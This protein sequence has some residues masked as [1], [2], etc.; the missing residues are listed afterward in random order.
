MSMI[1]VATLCGV[2]RTILLSVHDSSKEKK[3]NRRTQGESR[4]CKFNSSSEMGCSV[5]WETVEHQ[6]LNRFKVMKKF[7]DE[8]VLWSRQCQ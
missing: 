1:H 5:H 6:F 4:L 8:K 3:S 2:F 7:S